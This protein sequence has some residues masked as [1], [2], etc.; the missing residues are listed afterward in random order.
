MS[1]TCQISWTTLKLRKYY[2]GNGKYSQKEF[3]VRLPP[4][5]IAFE[6]FKAHQSLL[7]GGLDKIPQ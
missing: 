1:D 6:F 4:E 2:L 3:A 5:D 7:G